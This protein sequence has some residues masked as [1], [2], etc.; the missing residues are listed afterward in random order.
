M[1]IR[2]LV[3][4]RVAS[5]LLEHAPTALQCTFVIG[6]SDLVETPFVR[7]YVFCLLKFPSLMPL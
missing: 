6:F 2:F 3:P 1:Y 4:L 5:E 7:K